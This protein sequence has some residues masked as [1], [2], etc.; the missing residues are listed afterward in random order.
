[1]VGNKDMGENNGIAKDPKSEVY[2]SI[3]DS[4]V[5][6]TKPPELSKKGEEAY[7]RIL[8]L[9]NA[10]YDIAKET[11][12]IDVHDYIS[13]EV[14]SKIRYMKDE[15][16]EYVAVLP[17]KERDLITKRLKED[18]KAYYSAWP[19]IRGLGRGGHILNDSKV[20][21]YE[22]ER[23]IGNTK[24]LYNRVEASIDYDDKGRIAGPGSETYDRTKKLWEKVKGEKHW[25]ELPEEE[26]QIWEKYFSGEKEEGELKEAGAKEE[27]K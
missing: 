11:G 15:I 25:Q 3:M 9:E 20:L 21:Y 26:K 24:E 10:C 18:P 16:T 5:E 8:G 4:F 17:E 23:R 13:E 27:S 1:M 7:S 12:K 22:I 2:N 19:V 14:E 6:A